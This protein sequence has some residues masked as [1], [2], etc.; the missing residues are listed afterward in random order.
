MRIVSNLRYICFAG[1]LVVRNRPIDAGAQAIKHE[2]KFASQAGMQ[3]CQ[4]LLRVIECLLSG[5]EM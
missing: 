1:C 3:G 4:G 2:V 5:K